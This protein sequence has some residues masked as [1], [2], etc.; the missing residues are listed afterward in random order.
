[1]SF[2]KRQ[3]V[4]AAFDE[5][6]LSS[7]TFDLAPD[8]LQSALEKLEMMIGSWSG[9][10]IFIGYPIAGN[11]RDASLSEDTDV[12]DSALEAIVTNLAVR[13]APMYGK[14]V[15]QETKML[16][17]ESYNVLVAKTVKT[18]EMQFPS[19]LPRGAGSR[20]RTDQKYFPEPVSNETNPDS[21][22]FLNLN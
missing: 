6:G 13:L 15:S 18:V 10:N 4:N 2:T 17:K 1:M 12:P 3:F 11:P 22:L 20:L 8:Q 14:T 16:A 7:Y 21:P 19:T 5:L 9:R